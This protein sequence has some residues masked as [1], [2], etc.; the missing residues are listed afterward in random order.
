[1]EDKSQE[2]EFECS[3]CKEMALYSYLKECSIC[4]RPKCYQCTHQLDVIKLSN[5]LNK[6]S[7]ECEKCKRIGCGE[8]IVTCHVCGCAEVNINIACV[9]CIPF[10]KKNICNVHF[11]YICNNCIFAGEKC[12]A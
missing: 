8:C 7:N 11:S 9:D 5:K 2:S 1:M 3:C 6:I 10:N 12:I 4:T